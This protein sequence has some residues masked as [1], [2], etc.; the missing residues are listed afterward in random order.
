LRLRCWLKVVTVTEQ[1]RIHGGGARESGV[2]EEGDL[3]LQLLAFLF[4]M[5]SYISSYGAKAV[6]ISR[7]NF[8]HFSVKRS[9]SN[10]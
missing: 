3:P 10:K 5:S 9:T 6:A 1:Q 8:T 7:L 4:C 2:S